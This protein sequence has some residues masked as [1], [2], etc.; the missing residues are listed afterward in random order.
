MTADEMQ[1]RNIKA[2]GEPLGRQYTTMF[3]QLSLC[4]NSS[5]CCIF[6]GESFSNYS[7]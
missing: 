1:Q 2:M 6:I 7:A 5:R 3:E 4:L